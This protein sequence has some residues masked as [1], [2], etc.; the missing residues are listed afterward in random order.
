M[1]KIYLRSED[2]ANEYR[3]PLVPRDVRKLLKA[4][5]QVYVQT[6]KQRI[7]KD[8][9]YSKAGA[10]LT[11]RKWHHPS[12]KKA[13]IV[14]LKELSDLSYLDNHTH[15]YFSHTYKNQANW[16]EILSFFNESNSKIYDFEYFL[17]KF[18]RRLIAF[19]EYAGKV[20]T[21]LGLLQYYYRIN[22]I[23]MENL[24]PWPSYE[25]MY[26]A[27]SGKIVKEVKIAIVG[28]DGRCGSGVQKVLNVLKIPF[29]K[30]SKNANISVLLSYDIVFN[31][32]LLD[33]TYD[34]VWFDK[35]TVFTKPLV[36]VDLSCDYSK[37][38]NPIQIYEKS[39]TWNEPV[40][41]YNSNVDIIAIENLP[42]LLPKESSDEFSNKF[43]KLLLL[44]IENPVWFKN[45][46]IYRHMIEKVK[47][48]T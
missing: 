17:D 22:N 15:V 44:N 41:H 13:L 7:Y 4:G 6:S 32:I 1:Y 25:A 47:K 14:G 5:F 19:G 43:R 35:N 16:Q 11:T 33:E 31:C 27:L 30:I 37:P 42:S 10:I 8:A 36:I 2:L 20:A 38:N 24:K 9:E 46:E 29:D 12:Y 40:L 34:K 3:S 26:E 45:L 48:L 18:N 39:T 23:T 28:A 21:A